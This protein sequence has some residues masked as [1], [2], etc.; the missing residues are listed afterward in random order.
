MATQGARRKL[1]TAIA[2]NRQA[3]DELSEIKVREF[4]FRRR[5]DRSNITSQKY[6]IM[7]RVQKVLYLTHDYMLHSRSCGCLGD[8]I[9]AILL[10]IDGAITHIEATAKSGVK[11]QTTVLQRAVWVYFKH[12]FTSLDQIFCDD[13]CQAFRVLRNRFQAAVSEERLESCRIQ[14]TDVLAAIPAVNGSPP[15]SQFLARIAYLDSEVACCPPRVT[16]TANALRRYNIDVGNSSNGTQLWKVALVGVRAWI[17]ADSNLLKVRNSQGSGVDV[18]KS[19]GVFLVPPQIPVAVRQKR[20]RRRACDVNRRRTN[21]GG[22]RAPAAHAVRHA[23]PHT[24]SCS[25][26][27]SAPCGSAKGAWNGAASGELTHRLRALDIHPTSAAKDVDHR[28]S[29]LAQR[30]VPRTNPT[31]SERFWERV[32]QQ[33][34]FRLPPPPS[35]AH[36]A[37]GPYGFSMTDAGFPTLLSSPGSISPA[38]CSSEAET[39]PYW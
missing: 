33:Q 34:C 16:I 4:C 30:A 22:S 14:Y 17:E 12:V 26:L 25:P 32:G 9:R 6:S 27:A 8:V 10:N 18:T 24:P 3:L 1:L 37:N 11:Q 15:T 38:Q 29:G 28:V 20:S 35:R 7:M 31:S 5:W 23:S 39:A 13:V 21:T 2:F 36:G 19:N